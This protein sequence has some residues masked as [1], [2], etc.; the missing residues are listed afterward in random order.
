M[1]PMSL[2]P[3]SSSSPSSGPGGAGA[4]LSDPPAVGTRPG[5]LTRLD[6]RGREADIRDLLPAP[7]IG[8]E[9]LAES[10]QAVRTILDRVRVDGD[11]AVREL[12]WQ[13]D[14]V[15][16]DG[17]RVPDAEVTAALAD[18]PTELRTALQVAH[19]N[20]VTYHRTQLHHDTRQDRDGIVVRDLTIP[21]DRAG[22]YVPG[23]R[24]PLASTV[25]MTAGPKSGSP[26]W[27]G[28]Q[29]CSPS[30]ATG[31]YLPRRS[32]PRRPSPASTR[33]T[34]SAGPRPSPPWP[35]GPRAFLPLMSS[36]GP[37]T[38]TSPSPNDWSPATD[39][40][41][42]HPPLPGRPRWSWW[43]TTRLRSP[44]PRWTWWSR[45]START[46]WPT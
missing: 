11:L 26:G 33:C 7:T 40:S 10:T 37:A 9:G 31:Y 4:G 20:I 39:W 38:A 16:V 12:T 29:A 28:L 30:P 45:P 6:L 35:T 5:V 1:V 14:G 34:A 15:A 19:D 21:V 36:S 17:L 42:C 46:G 27:S 41:A 3:A 44:T 23:G 8:G 32:W 24:A 13:F 18:I 25:L 2:P 22:L 43:P